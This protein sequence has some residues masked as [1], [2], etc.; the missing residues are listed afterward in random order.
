[1]WPSITHNNP[2]NNTFSYGSNSNHASS[3][4][5]NDSWSHNLLRSKQSGY[6]AF[7]LCK[8]K[9][10][11]V[12]KLQIAQFQHQCTVVIKF[13]NMHKAI[14]AS[15][16]CPQGSESQSHGSYSYTNN[17]SPHVYYFPTNESYHIDNNH[18]S[19]DC[20]SCSCSPNGPNDHC[21]CSHSCEQTNICQSLHFAYLLPSH[22]DG[23][24]MATKNFLHL[25]IMTMTPN[26]CEMTPRNHIGCDF[27]NIQGINNNQTAVGQTTCNVLLSLMLTVITTPTTVVP[28]IMVVEMSPLTP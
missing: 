17:K 18:C 23:Y 9:C 5:C 8:E 1:M 24:F 11:I 4:T 13:D 22:N 12:G 20:C 27:L 25:F 7:T 6:D 3:S 14:I 2:S 26:Q 19:S 21:T 16:H 10:Q 28:S 15:C